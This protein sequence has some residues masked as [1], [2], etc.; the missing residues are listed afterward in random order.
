[1][2]VR[3]LIAALVATAP[4]LDAFVTCSAL[5][6]DNIVA[7][8]AGGVGD[9]STTDQSYVNIVMDSPQAWDA[10]TGDALESGVLTIE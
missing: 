6:G 3:Q 7:F 2:T 5:S 1:L 8:W 10:A 4:D 9:V